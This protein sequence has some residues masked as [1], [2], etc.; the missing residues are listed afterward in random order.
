[1]T[2]MSKVSIIVPVF[3][4]GQSLLRHLAHLQQFR[5]RG[6][7]VVLVDG[8]GEESD[9]ATYDELVDQLLLSPQGRAH[10]MNCG[11]AAA[12][13]DVLL[14]LHAD[15]LLPDDAL[16]LV[17]SGLADSRYRWGRF[18]VKLSG[19]SMLFSIIA[20]MMNLRSRLTGI[21]TG[22]QAIFVSTGAFRDVGGYPEQPLMEDIELCSRLCRTGRPL[23]L[24]PA[25]VTSSRRWEEHGTWRTIF[26][27]WRL[28]LAY[29]LGASPE[30]LHARYYLAPNSRNTQS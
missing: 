5:R 4:E 3:R 10:Q 7:E 28:R 17:L 26:L 16:E 24:K 1:M 30:K 23:C 27:M 25:V 8:G 13:G 11:A 12:G 14:F 19:H 22:D 18:D 9:D 6:H 20:T 15:T 2:L 29:F 21:C